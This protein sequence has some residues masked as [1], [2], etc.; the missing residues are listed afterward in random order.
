MSD[1]LSLLKFGYELREKEEKFEALNEKI[2]KRIEALNEKIEKKL[3]ELESQILR[4]Y[5]TLIERTIDNN[6]EIGRTDKRLSEHI[7]VFEALNFEV[8]KRI[9]DLRNSNLEL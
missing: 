4:N 3:A 9:R 7:R 2:H 1:M 6:C 5:N 8:H